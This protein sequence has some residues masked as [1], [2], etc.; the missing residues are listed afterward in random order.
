MM[1]KVLGSL[2]LAL[3]LAVVIAFFTN[4]GPEKHRDKLRSE[5]AA[6]SQ[7]A[8]LLQLGSLAAFASDYHTL[9]VASYSTVSGRT[10]SYGA[11]GMVFVPDLAGDPPTR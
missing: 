4:P 6:R 5:I 7:I 11:F 10:M 2:A 1:F 8:A 9:G 3:A